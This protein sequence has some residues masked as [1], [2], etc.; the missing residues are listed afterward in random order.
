MRFLPV[1]LT[2]MLV[3]LAD[4]DETLALFASLQ[5]NP[6]AGIDEMVPAAR[7]LM[8]RFRPQTICAEALAAEVSTHDLSAKLAPSDHL[9]EIPVDYDGEDLADVAELTGLAVEEVIRRHTESTFTVAFCGFAPGFGYLVG[10]DPALH[11][12]RRKSPRTRIPA[13]AVALAGAFS[14]VYPQASP[15]GWQI[16]GVTPVKMW[17]LS[18]DPPALFQPGYQVRFTDMAKAVYPVVIPAS[19][20]APSN[21]A[22]GFSETN[23]AAHFTV[24]AAPMPAVFQDLGRLGQTGQGVSASGALDQGA[25]KAANRVVGNPAGVPCLEITLGGFSFESDRRAVIALTGAPCPV[26]IRDASG[27]VTQAETYQPIALEPGDTVSL[28]QPPQ[29]MRS[30]LAV[31]GGFAVQPVLGSY[32]TDTLAVVGPEA[33][34]AGTV[35]TLKG[36][37]EGLTSVSLHESPPQNL[38]SAGDIVTLDVVLGPRTDW[39]TERGLATLTDQL[40]QVTPQSSRVGIRLAGDMPL[41][42]IDSAELPSEGTA[43]GAIQVPHSGQPVLF[44]ADHPLTGGYPVIGT[45]AEYHLDLAGQIP[46]NARIRFRPIAP[47]ADIAPAP[48]PVL[49]PAANA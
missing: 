5:A 27:R 48:T 16:I 14:G 18:R 32:A 46:I 33:V 6:V 40:W 19:D 35:L 8:I 41:E 17:D 15:G 4:L 12:P 34:T 20:A 49:G 29:G 3:E 9:V 30:Y 39:F 10:G 45:V 42:R 21:P 1:S 43:T 23:G 31:R 22:D 2:T 38:P 13:G 26:T 36:S 28:G 44:L 7:T 11:V 24:L 37:S 47:F 25:L